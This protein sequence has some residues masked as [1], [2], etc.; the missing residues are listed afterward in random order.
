[1]ASASP[2][3]AA[4]IAQAQSDA[5]IQTDVAF[6]MYVPQL[7]TIVKSALTSLSTS[8]LISGADQTVIKAQLALAA[9]DS[10]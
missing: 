10:G 7:E 1:M 5:L 3:V 6:N 8:A 9:G 2:M 4:C